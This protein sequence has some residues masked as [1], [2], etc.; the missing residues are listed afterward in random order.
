MS[1]FSLVMINAFVVVLVTMVCLFDMTLS[2]QKETKNPQLHFI[3][4]GKEKAFRKI[5]CI[6]PADAAVL[7]TFFC[8]TVFVHCLFILFTQLPAKP[9]KNLEWSSLSVQ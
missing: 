7:K 8:S 9:E 5:Y 6:F 1:C 3:L 2:F 4:L